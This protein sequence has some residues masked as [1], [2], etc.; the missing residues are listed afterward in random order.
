MAIV[1]TA[2]DVVSMAYP[3]PLIIRV[4]R[5]TE[6]PLYAT[7]DFEG[8]LWHGERCPGQTVQV[9]YRRVTHVTQAP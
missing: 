6:C 7:L 8:H 9:E 3:A 4:Y 2:D 1:P 5:C